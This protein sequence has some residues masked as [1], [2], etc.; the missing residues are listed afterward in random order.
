MTTIEVTGLRKRFGPT[1]A[2]DGMTAER[3]VA[4]L[5]AQATS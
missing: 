5:A 1:Q 4:L 3:I 2:L